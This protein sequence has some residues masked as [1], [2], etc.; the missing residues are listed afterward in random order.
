MSNQLARQTCNEH[1]N[2]IVQ[3]WITGLKYPDALSL[4]HQAHTC[5][6]LLDSQL[7]AIQPDRHRPRI[8]QLHIHACPEYAACDLQPIC[9]DGIFKALHQG[10]SNCRRRRVRKTGA[11]SFARICIEGELRYDEHLAAGVEQ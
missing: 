2:Q 8:E 7:L 4:A 1:V 3:K 10:L 9:S 5:N 6:L 11:A